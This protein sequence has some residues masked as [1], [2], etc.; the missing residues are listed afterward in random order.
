MVPEK[1]YKFDKKVNFQHFCLFGASSSHI[2]QQ[3]LTKFFFLKDQ[4]K[5][6]RKCIQIVRISP[7][8]AKLR[9]ETF[10]A[11][12]ALAAKKSGFSTFLLFWSPFRPYW[13]T[14]VAQMLTKKFFSERSLQSDS[15]MYLHRSDISNIREVTIGDVL[16][17]S[18]P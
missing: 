14:G 1:V 6:T 3:V 13:S 4:F 5:V 8:F 18:G 17:R 15:K 10:C 12:A 7:I 16:R 11:V 2:G 9:L